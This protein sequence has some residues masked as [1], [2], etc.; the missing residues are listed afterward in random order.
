MTANVNVQATAITRARYDRVAPVYDLMDS[1]VELLLKDLRPKIWN[2]ARG[3]ILEVGVGTGRNFPYHPAGSRIV[4]ID[5]SKRM[6]ERAYR[7]TSNSKA[8]PVL[9]QGDV[10]ALAF[11]DNSFDTAVATCVFCSVPDPV[12]GLCELARVVKPGGRVLLLEHVQIDQP[13]IGEIMDAINPFFVPLY[14]ANINRRTIDNVRKAGLR[15]E[16]VE[17]Y[18]PMGMI[19]LI[20]AQPYK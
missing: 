7:R 2:L 18:G 11:S 17:H 14:G 16:R 15:I 19:K 4:G 20:I 13:V 8:H 10:Q 12:L 1:L 3:D 9:R 6:L 5:L